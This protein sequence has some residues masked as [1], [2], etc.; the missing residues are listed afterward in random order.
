MAQDANEK[1]VYCKYC[2]ELLVNETQLQHNARCAYHP[3]LDC[4]DENS[5]ECLTCQYRTG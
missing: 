1:L 3:C 2:N 4:P 5:N